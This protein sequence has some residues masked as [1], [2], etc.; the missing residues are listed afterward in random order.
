MIACP[1][2]VFSQEK[3]GLSVS[4]YGGVYAAQTNPSAPA[5]S[6]TFFDLNLFGADLFLENNFMFIHKDDYRL[7]EFL[8]RS[9]KLPV[10]GVPGQGVDYS[11]TGGLVEGYQQLEMTGPSVSFTFGK[12]SVGL[13]SRV[14]TVTSIHDLPRDIAVLLYEGIDY[15]SLWGI[16]QNDGPF[17]VSTAGWW[18]IGANYA[19]AFKGISIGE[20]SLGMNLRMLFGYAGT[21]I[22]AQNI[23]YTVMN[24]TTVII[25]NMDAEIGFSIPMDLETNDFPDNDPLFKGKGVAV[26]LGATYIRRK[27]LPAKVSPR[28]FCEYEYED[29]HF[30]LGLSMRGLGRINFR[31]NAQ[32]HR[33][34]GVSADWTNLDTVSYYNIKELTSKFSTVFYGDPDASLQADAYHLGLPASVNFQ[35]DYQ[36]YPH[37]YLN[38]M[39]V[40]PVKIYANQLHRPSQAILSLRYETSRFEVNM[41]L[42]LYNFKK[43]RLGLYVRL[44][45]FSIGTEK[46]GGFFH[47]Q[48]FTGMDLYV[49]MKFHLR[50][51][52]CTRY[53]PAKDCRHLTF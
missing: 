46:L 17:S 31:K 38:A 28:R 20:F 22:Q 47:F 48:D 36:Y 13:F 4:N 33:Y 21:T 40:L 27:E 9:P 23:D 39:V 52:Y 8:S 53:K 16:N 45:Y 6:K 1:L 50:K 30:K 32:Q 25:R 7:V 14:H 29:Y 37:W 15:D 43:P 5:F 34:S 35:A 2:N 24:D 18:E 41:P 10:F 11:N 49:S 19:Y 26:D 12:Q 42:S 51:G 44:W 3:P